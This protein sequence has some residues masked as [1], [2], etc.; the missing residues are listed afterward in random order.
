MT[1]H[2]PIPSQSAAGTF[3]LVPTEALRQAHP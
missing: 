2:S 1:V 3:R